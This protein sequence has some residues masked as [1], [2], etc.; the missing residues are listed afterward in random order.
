MGLLLTLTII[1]VF[2]HLI[3]L[4]MWHVPRLELVCALHVYGYRFLVYDEHNWL[5]HTM[6][7]G[8]LMECS[9][10]YR[11]VFIV[12]LATLMR[13]RTVS[14]T[15]TECLYIYRVYR[16]GTC[17]QFM[18]M[19]SSWSLHDVYLSTSWSYLQHTCN[20]LY[21]LLRQARRPMVKLS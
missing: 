7:L 18:M 12:H 15:S 13:T 20:M 1:H 19:A 4:W 10:H 11:V 17:L 16:C 3:N 6:A 14:G 9:W 5:D 8:A 21:L 2:C